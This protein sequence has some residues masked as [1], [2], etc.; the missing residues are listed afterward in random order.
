MSRRPRTPLI[1]PL[2]GW[3]LVRLARRGQSHRG[4]L[5]VAYLLLI[6]FIIT[7]VFWFSSDISI[8]PL[9]I[10][11][12][13]LRPMSLPDAAA[14][15]RRFALVLLEAVLFAVAAMT[16]GYA[17]TAVAD[18]KERQTLPLLLTTPLADRE[19]VLG[20]AAARLVFVLGAA[21]A[22]VPILAVT[23]LVGGVET[24]FLLAAWGL[25]VGTAVLC[26]AIGVRAACTT[27]DLRAALVSAYGT[28]AL[29]VGAG[30]IPPFS[31]FSPFAMLVWMQ[32]PDP[33]F[34]PRVGL[35]IGV[36][37]PAI[38]CL[39]A[40]A[41]FADAVRKLRREDLTVR[42]PPRPKFTLAPLP[43]REPEPDLKADYAEP[44]DPT[45]EPPPRPGELPRVPDDDPLLW[46]ERY[47]SGMRTGSGDGARTAAVLIA[48][49]AMIL[50]VI[51]MWQLVARL[52]AT[53]P[54]EDD[55]GRLVMTGGVILTGVYL[56]P[57]SVGLA[58]AVARERRRQTLDPLLALPMTRRE[59]LW[60]KV[61]AAIQRGWWWAPMAIAA[62]AVS[63]GADGGWGPGLTAPAFVLAGLWFVVGLGAD[64]T[65]RC[66]SEVRAFRFLVPAVV[67][68]V[69][70]PVGIWNYTDW[71]LPFWSAVGLAAGAVAF[72]LA[73]T[74]FWRR[75]VWALDHLGAPER[76]AAPEAGA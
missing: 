28:T 18:E 17:A 3:E 41:L 70:A 76:P 51:G 73:G 9:D 53:R 25:V 26:I 42:P 67:V 32:N 30:V 38:Q 40:L 61:R 11:F 21:L 31:A 4:R 43:L 5:L 1:G 47:V 74:V 62:T 65:V 64:L 24:G 55:G 54:Q 59:V 57:A 49:L 35:I 34:M 56:F 69:G 8:G 75:A 48:G 58:S 39:I 15:G 27:D 68:V 50:M 23:G 20:K 29:L 63:F 37:Y 16:P 45:N 44:D 10:F 46:K 13:T 71:T 12:G 66:T 19:I 33:S 22:A 36:V 72:A 6:A 7:P 14:F 60:T 52:S 2:A